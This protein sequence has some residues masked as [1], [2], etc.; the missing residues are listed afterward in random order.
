MI[1]GSRAPCA[2][3]QFGAFG[4]STMLSPSVLNITRVPR[5][6][7]DLLLGP[8]DHAVTLAGLLVFAALRCAQSGKSWRF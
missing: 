8:L 7:A 3:R 2:A 5:I 1:N 6:F 4:T